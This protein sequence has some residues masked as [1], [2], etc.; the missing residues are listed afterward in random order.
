MCYVNAR[1]SADG[2]NCVYRK[3]V[4]LSNLNAVTSLYFT[5]MRVY[6]AIYVDVDVLCAVQPGDPCLSANCPKGTSSCPYATCASGNYTYQSSYKWIN[7]TQT[8]PM[9]VVSTGL[10]L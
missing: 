4:L 2:I 8:G 10:P 1:P 7:V 6:L 3:L 9:C 5:I